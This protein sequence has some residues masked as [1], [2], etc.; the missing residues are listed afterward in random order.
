MGKNFFPCVFA[1]NV[2]Y[3]EMQPQPMGEKNQLEDSK[4]QKHKG[5]KSFFQLS[6]IWTNSQV[7]VEVP[8]KCK[9]VVLDG[10][11]GR[12]PDS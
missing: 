2:V 7:T 12:A 4:G 1:L 8:N 3:I 5:H 9:C 11:V 10:S 6:F